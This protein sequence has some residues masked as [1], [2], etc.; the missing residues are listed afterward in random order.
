LQLIARAPPPADPSSGFL[1][2]FAGLLRK[3]ALPGA[4]L[5]AFVRAWTVAGALASWTAY[6]VFGHQSLESIGP[7]VGSRS[8]TP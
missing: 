3:S 4:G 1:Y 8:Y 5:A 2:N 6:Q 7:G